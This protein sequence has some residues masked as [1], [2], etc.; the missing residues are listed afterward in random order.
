MIKIWF[1]SKIL[2]YIKNPGVW[3]QIV[4]RVWCLIIGVRCPWNPVECPWIL[5]SHGIRG[6]GLR[7]HGPLWTL[8]PGCPRIPAGSHGVQGSSHSSPSSWRRRG[9]GVFCNVIF[10]LFS[11]SGLHLAGILMRGC[12]FRRSYWN[13]S[14]TVTHP[15]HDFPNIFVIWALL[16]W[17]SAFAAVFTVKSA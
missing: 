7:T 1:I 13:I 9:T 10:P 3:I 14:W 12:L 2:F 4:R 5:D 17:E 15:S 8:G 11:S 16:G 6:G